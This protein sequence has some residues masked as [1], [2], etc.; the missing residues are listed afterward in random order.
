MIT[1][2][3]QRKSSSVLYFSTSNKVPSV[4]DVWSNEG[5]ILNSSSLLQVI[6]DQVHANFMH[7]RLIFTNFGQDQFS[8]EVKFLS[9]GHFYYLIYHCNNFKFSGGEKWNSFGSQ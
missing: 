9:L 6:L 2:R 8:S 4:L 3:N 1:L 5:R 7:F